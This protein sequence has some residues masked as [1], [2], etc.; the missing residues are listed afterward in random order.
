MREKQSGAALIVAMV[1]LLLL[2]LLGTGSIQTV[3]FDARLSK[4]MQDRSYAFQL[5]ETGLRTAESLLSSIED[6]QAVAAQAGAAGMHFETGTA[7]YFDSA[8]WQ[9]I[10]LGT[11]AHPVKIVVQ[12]WRFVSD[13]LVVGARQPGG[14]TYY[15]V[16]SRGTDPG[17]IDWLS[18]GNAERDNQV[19]SEAIV[20]S[21]YAVRHAD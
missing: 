12:R 8:Y 10:A 15:L 13:S 21:V 7:D 19:R 5:A 16:T 4:G 3:T 17:Y 20:Q 11:A 2:T 14:I 18:A 6:A 1:V 9:T